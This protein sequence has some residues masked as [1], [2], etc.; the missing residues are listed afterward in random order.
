MQKHSQISFLQSACE[1]QIIEWASHG[2]MSFYQHIFCSFLFFSWQIFQEEIVQ[3]DE[4]TCELV[5][6]VRRE[7]LSKDK[8]ESSELQVCYSNVLTLH[9]HYKITILGQQC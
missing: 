9:L 7:T 3:S 4:E 2:I 1:N 5:R 6:Q 8:K